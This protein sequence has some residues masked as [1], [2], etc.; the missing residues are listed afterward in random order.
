MSDKVFRDPLYNYIAIDRKRDGWLLKLIDTPEVQRIRR[1]HQ[2]GVSNIT[3][4][5]ADHNRLAHSLGVVYLMQRVLDSLEKTNDAER[6]K[7]ARQPLLAA[8]L[9][10]DVGHGPYS[11]LFEP[12]LGINH[13]YWS[14]EVI[15]NPETNINKILLQEDQYLP[16]QVASLIQ[17]NDP[18]LPNLAKIFII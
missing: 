8:A 16:K 17:E 14:I 12:C 11:H 3:Y 13:E 15:L 6:I 18:R 5:G 2:L 9:L 7:R 10:H 1:I 4:P